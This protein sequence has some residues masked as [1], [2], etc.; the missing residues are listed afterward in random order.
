MM[1]KLLQV[2]HRRVLSRQRGTL[3]LATFIILLYLF[4]QRS[5]RTEYQVWRQAV[6]LGSTILG[7]ASSTQPA[8]EKLSWTPPTPVSDEAPLMSDEEIKELF[9]TEYDALGK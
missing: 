8:S 2:Q 7:G 5:Q 9:K 4:F 1:T 6:D 3:Y